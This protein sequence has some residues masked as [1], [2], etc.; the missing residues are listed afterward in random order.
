MG[1]EGT[2]ERIALGLEALVMQGDVMMKLQGFNRDGSA[3]ERTGA[4]EPTP[5]ESLVNLAGGVV[6]DPAS[7]TWCS[8]PVRAKTGDYTKEERESL[9][10]ELREEGIEFKERC[11]NPTLHQMI[12]DGDGTQAPEPVVDTPTEDTGILGASTGAAAP[13]PTGPLP[14]E[15]P[16]ELS[17]ATLKPLLKEY[18]GKH[19][20]DKA[21][22]LLKTVGVSK[23]SDA[24]PEQMVKVKE[25][26]DRG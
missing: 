9:K 18:A 15:A 10:T 25:A 19:G 6:N 12:V 21:K 20:V 5:G 17:H 24:N 26:I 3:I 13:A 14:G 1:L 23:I 8:T 16:V 2:L 22:A 4:A 7:T 11:G